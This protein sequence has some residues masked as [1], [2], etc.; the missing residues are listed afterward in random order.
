MNLQN[1]FNVIEENDPEIYERLNS[2]RRVMHQFTK[3]AGKFSLTALPFALGSMLNKAY[4]QT[5]SNIVDILN[6]ALKLEYLESDFYST[7]ISNPNLISADE[8]ASFNLIQQHE[9]A[10][11]SFLTSTITSLQGTAIAKPEFDFTANGTYPN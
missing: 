7:A 8:T 3:I 11:V 10:H 2:R 9:A 1:I 4:G 6:F 5:S